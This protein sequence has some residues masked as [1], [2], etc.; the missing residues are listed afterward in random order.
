MYILH[1]FTCN[2]LDAI[3]I[4]LSVGKIFTL[5]LENKRQLNTNCISYLLVYFYISYNVHMLF[6]VKDFNTI[7]L[8]MQKARPS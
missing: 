8:D 4:R 1:I 7:E 3:K 6:Y 5:N 2:A